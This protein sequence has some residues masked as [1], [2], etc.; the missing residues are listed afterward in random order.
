MIEVLLAL[1]LPL[2]EKLILWLVGLGADPA[3]VNAVT[4][5]KL[6]VALTRMKKIDSLCSQVGIA[7]QPDVETGD[8][9]PEPVA[10]YLNATERE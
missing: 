8:I 4:K 7:P 10:A 6:G 1:L 3:K 2:L 5:A 9:L